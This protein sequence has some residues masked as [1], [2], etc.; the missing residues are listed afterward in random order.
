MD[1]G[2][3]ILAELDN[4]LACQT[5]QAWLD[6]A[7]AEQTTLLI[8]HANCEKKA[9]ATAM[10]L[11]YRYV[12]NSELLTKMAQLAREEL[13]HFQQLVELMDQRNIKYIRLSPSRYAAGLRQHIDH[14]DS[15][16]MV[17]TLIVGALIEA[18]SCERFAR[19]AP[20][21]DAEL[22]RFY[23]N[24]LK[25]EARHYRDYL[26]LAQQ[27]SKQNLEPRIAH[28][29]AVE[30]ELISSPDPQFRFHSGVPQ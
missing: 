18:R 21:L 14:H 20:L 4:F 26:Q 16:V 11:M 1:N 15:H 17:D 29:V 10:N 22:S 24:L 7:V 6:V 12:G 25:S 5:S 13:L 27:Y 30:A 19:V 28:F 3:N 2:M 9:A 8:D 23:R